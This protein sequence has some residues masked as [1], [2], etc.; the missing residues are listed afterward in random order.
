MAHFQAARIN[1]RLA[2]FLP[3]P[4]GEGRGEGEGSIGT[5]SDVYLQK[6]LPQVT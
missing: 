2:D 6:T 3:L 5:C 4:K 1:Q